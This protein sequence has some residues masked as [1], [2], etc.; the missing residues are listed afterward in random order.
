MCTFVFCS[1]VCIKTHCARPF[2]T[3]HV[4]YRDRK[5]YCIS[6]VMI[7]NLPGGFWKWPG[8]KL[9]V[10]QVILALGTFFIFDIVK[11]GGC[12]Y[13]LVFVLELTKQIL[14]GQSLQK[15]W[16]QESNARGHALCEMASK[17]K[18]RTGKCTKKLSLYCI[19]TW[20][21]PQRW[22]LFWVGLPDMNWGRVP[23]P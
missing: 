14:V 16:K 5:K 8:H 15:N 12:V 6:E 3:F 18:Q 22:S 23:V 20:T 17:E 21:G 10:L 1:S 11:K 7:W 13:N 19:M 2:F 4:S 9:C